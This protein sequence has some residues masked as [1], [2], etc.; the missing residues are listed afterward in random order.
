MTLGRFVCIAPHC[1]HVQL[2]NEDPV[3]SHFAC[4]QIRVVASQFRT[5]GWVSDQPTIRPLRL[6][7]SQSNRLTGENI[8]NNE[9]IKSTDLNSKLKT[10]R[11]Q[12][13]RFQPGGNAQN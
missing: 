4:M 13:D 8:S 11:R 6:G 1:M 5:P 3:L 9:Y 2:C 10:K 7:L 12:P